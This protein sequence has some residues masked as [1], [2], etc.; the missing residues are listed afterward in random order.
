MK[1]VTGLSHDQV[2]LF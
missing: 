2:A 1:V